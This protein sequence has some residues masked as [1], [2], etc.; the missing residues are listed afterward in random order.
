M[1]TGILVVV[2]SDLTGNRL[3]NDRSLIM[4][5]SVIWEKMFVLLLLTIVSYI[6]RNNALDCPLRFP[7]A[8]NGGLHCCQYSKEKTD[9]EYRGGHQD[10]FCDGSD[11]TLESK[12]CKDDQYKEC[13]G[14]SCVTPS[15]E[16]DPCSEDYPNP[17]YHGLYCCKTT[18]EKANFTHRATGTACQN[19]TLA[20]QSECCQNDEYIQCVNPPCVTMDYWSLTWNAEGNDNGA[21]AG[22]S[23]KLRVPSGRGVTIGRGYD[24]KARLAASIKTD[25]KT[26]GIS[27]GN[28]TTLSNG[29]QKSGTEAN[30]FITSNNLQTYTI[31][32]QQQWKLFKITLEQQITKIKQIYSRSDL[33]TVDF[34]TRVSAVKGLVVDLHI[35][36]DYTEPII[37]LLHS[38]IVSNDVVGL[39]DV[40]GNNTNWS[41]VP[42]QR[43]DLR[44][45]YMEKAS[46]S[47]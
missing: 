9:Y 6:D 20:L 19:G 44:K 7:Y 27:D 26:A 15:F 33:T 32:H 47:P 37:Q 31:T 18:K 34:D 1:I 14:V 39:K 41:N 38:K 11:I 36:G 2:F 25:L 8:Y 28:A 10:E 24:M 46:S 12:C 23:R 29:G 5:C 21:D 17:Y 3:L 30:T 40:V 45:A 43:F 4:A 16:N 35:T 13:P 42:Q 22:F